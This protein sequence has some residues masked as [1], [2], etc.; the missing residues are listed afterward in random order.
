MLKQFNESFSS[1]LFPSFARNVSNSLTSRSHLEQRGAFKSINELASKLTSLFYFISIS[2]CVSRNDVTVLL[3]SDKKIS[4]VVKAKLYAS[5]LPQTLIIQRFVFPEKKEEGKKNHSFKLSNSIYTRES[6]HAPMGRTIICFVST[7]PP[8]R[9]FIVVRS[10]VW[11]RLPRATILDA[12][13]S[14]FR[15]IDCLAAL[16][17]LFPSLE[18]HECLRGVNQPCRHEYSPSES[19]L[20]PPFS[21]VFKFR[22][23][24]ETSFHKSEASFNN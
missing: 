15:E 10:T 3:L 12:S 17:T 11:V 14:S 4:L 16:P 6:C 1:R 23:N 7:R 2:L 13:V 18:F 24:R 22:N 20:I 9:P 5:L 21:R 8:L 19:P